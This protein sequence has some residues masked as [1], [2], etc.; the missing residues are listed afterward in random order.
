MKVFANIIVCQRCQKKP[1]D[2]TAVHYYVGGTSDCPKE[3]HREWPCRK[4]WAIVG[5]HVLLEQDVNGC[6][7][8]LDHMMIQDHEQAKQKHM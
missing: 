6:P 2:T 1:I 4:L 7:Y 8:F 5:D 3:I